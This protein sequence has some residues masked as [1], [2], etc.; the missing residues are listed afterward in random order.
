MSNDLKLKK[1]AVVNA[2][3]V[4][5]EIYCLQ[6]KPGAPGHTVEL[7]LE[8]AGG[9]TQQ[10]GRLPASFVGFIMEVAGVASWSEVVGRIIRVRCSTEN[11]Y[12]L[13]HVLD[14]VWYPVKDRELGGVS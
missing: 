11:V 3:V 13:G 2:R 8:Y 12:A 14:E 1:S 5:A 4:S 9:A 7:G 10:T 6:L